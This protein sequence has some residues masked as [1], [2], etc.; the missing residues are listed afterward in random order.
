MRRY[1]RIEDDVDVKGRWFLDGLSDSKGR[2]LDSRDFIYGLSIEIGPPLR[3]SLADQDVIVD[4]HDPL[5]VSLRTEG[6][7]LDFTFA[8]FEMPVV[9][10]RV[11][12]LLETICG[13]DIQRIAVE[14]PGRNSA[15]EIINVVPCPNCIDRQ[16]S[17]VEWWTEADGR[18]EKLG[19][20][21]MVTKLAIDNRKVGEHHIF[22]PDGWVVALVV[23]DV[24]KQAIEN[25]R[26]SG[27]KFKAL[28]CS[29]VDHCPGPLDVGNRRDGHEDIQK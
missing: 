23:S 25:A 28:L 24:V 13:P 5:R 19:K 22:R 7:A 18:P 3:I 12:E 10:A 15:F 21:R 6:I 17:E 8:D 11:A 26:V 4:V 29:A 2:R 1:Y 9:T 14:V 27:V 16:R 20:P